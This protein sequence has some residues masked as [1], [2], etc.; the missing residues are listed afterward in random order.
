MA[1][2]QL[3]IEVNDEEFKD[4]CANNI[5]ALP[6][7][8]LNE[9]LLKAVEVALIRDKNNPSYDRDSNILVRATSNSAYGY[10]NR[11][12]EPTDLLNAIMERVDLS[13][14]VGNM[15][16]VMRDY[17]VNNYEEIIRKYVVEKFAEMLFTSDNQYAFRSS[18][19][20]E[21]NQIT[22]NR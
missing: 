19:M 8:K 18:I 20:S 1:N 5:N 14:Y 7:D 12:Y 11:E 2:L 9:L 10:Y 13:E 6:K 16:N 21:L 3:N 15:A 22:R 17:I 4:L